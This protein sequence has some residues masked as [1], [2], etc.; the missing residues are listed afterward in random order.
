MF[1]CIFMF[2]FH[3]DPQQHI[4]CD[5]KQQKKRRFEALIIICYRPLQA[6]VYDRS[7]E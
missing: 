4:T 1:F 7:Q 3:P 6:V 5:I 2:E